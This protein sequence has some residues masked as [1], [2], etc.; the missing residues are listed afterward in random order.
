MM[1]DPEH[2]RQINM[3]CPICWYPID[4]KAR[5][6]SEFIATAMSEI[7]PYKTR[8]R[9]RA[10]RDAGMEERTSAGRFPSMIKEHPTAKEGHTSSSTLTM[11]VFIAVGVICATPCIFKKRMYFLNMSCCLPTA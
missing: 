3:Y 11:A 7:G 9:I 6:C 8:F 2:D 1:T 4:N 10:T 5:A